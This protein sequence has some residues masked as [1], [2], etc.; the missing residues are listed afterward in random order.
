MS[1][2]VGGFWVAAPA[3]FAPK[4]RV[5]SGVERRLDCRGKLTASQ[6][7][8]LRHDLQIAPYSYYR[9]WSGY[10]FG[11]MER[12]RCIFYRKRLLHPR[13]SPFAAS[14]LGWFRFHSPPFFRRDVATSPRAPGAMA[15]G[16]PRRCGPRIRRAI[17]LTHH[18]HSVAVRELSSPKS[19]RS[20]PL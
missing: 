14:P 10:G 1:F 12:K 4:P 2:G 7:A 3:L 13:N 16:V 5:G 11:Y 6:G 15:P 17:T 20:R 8:T 19:M 18:L 9:V